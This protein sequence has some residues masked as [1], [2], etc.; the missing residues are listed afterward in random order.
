[1]HYE[2][3]IIDYRVVPT[4]L[5]RPHPGAWRVHPASQIALITALLEQVGWVNPILIYCSSSDGAYLVLNDHGRYQLDDEVPCLVLDITDSEAERLLL[6]LDITAMS[7][8][9]DQ[10][11]LE[12]L[13]QRVA[14]LGSQPDQDE[15]LRQAVARMDRAFA[16]PTTQI[17]PHLQATPS[18]TIGSLV[19]LGRHRMY[20]G[21][22]TNCE[23]VS[24]LAQGYSPCVMWTDP[25]WGVTLVGRTSA[26]M[27]IINDTPE[28]AVRVFGGGLKG[29]AAILSAGS[30]FYAVHPSNHMGLPMLQTLADCGFPV[31]QTLV[32]AKNRIIIGHGDYHNQHEMI[33]FGY[34]PSEQRCGRGYRHW[35]GGNNRSTLLAMQCPSRSD[36]HPTT[37]PVEV[38]ERLLRDVC[39]YDSCVYDPFLGSGSTLIAAERLNIRCIGCEI[40]PVYASAIVDRWEGETGQRAELVGGI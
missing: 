12:R 25:P 24:R 27:T 4:S 15:A 19:Q 38:V 34:T 6:N 13:R 5:L 31:R 26:A 9:V 1:M 3:R 18:L 17:V 28:D 40:D 36:Q 7:A 22:A 14:A 37:K 10:V 2:N 30:P 32:L 23:A 21:D 33:A 29:A 11:A 20:V 35:Y 16:A 39:A 8:R